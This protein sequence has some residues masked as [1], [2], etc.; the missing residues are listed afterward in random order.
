MQIN[1][2]K[3]I[4]IRAL[5]SIYVNRDK[6]KDLATNQMRKIQTSST[7][8]TFKETWFAGLLMI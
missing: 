4:T 5:L 2:E 7:T 3:L 8:T 6:M 1:P